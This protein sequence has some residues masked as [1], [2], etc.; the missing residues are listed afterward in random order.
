MAQALSFHNT[1]LSWKIAFRA[2]AAFAFLY[3]VAPSAA[4]AGYDI[5]NKTSY[6][7]EAAV[8]SQSSDGSITTQGWLDILPGSCRAVLKGKLGS[9]PLYLF[10]RTPDY[11]DQVLNK[12][13]G[14][15]RLCVSTGEFT[16]SNAAQCTDPAHSYANFIEITPRGEN[17]QTSLT[18]E[19]T[20]K[21][22]GAAMA[23]IQRLLAMTGYDIGSIDGVAGN[24]TNRALDDFMAKSGL[25]DAIKTSPQVIR[26]LVATVKKRQTESGLQVCNETRH[27]VWTTIG[28]HKGESIVT[29]GWYK[30]L[31]GECIRPVR[32]PLDGQVLYSFGEAV[33]KDGP[34]IAKGTIPLIWDGAVELCTSDKRFTIGQQENCESRGLKIT[35]FRKIDLGG[36]KSWTIRYTEPQ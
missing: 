19:T 35:K 29:Q 20:Y 27:L 23:G 8:G 34:V 15:R 22:D 6:V 3:F 24:M 33:D 16:I 4:Q 25:Q 5:C 13:S 26:A 11:Y 2:L 10:A 31:P 14:G 17:W 21:A 9:S 32:K 28:L 36:A 18:E 7:M 1:R 30:V 12:F